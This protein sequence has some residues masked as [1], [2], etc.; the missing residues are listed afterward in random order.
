MSISRRVARPLLAS[1]FV[2]GGLDALRN[3]EGKVKVA[4]PV[5]GPIAAHV[6]FLPEDTATLVRLNGGVMVGAAVLLAL[7]KLRRLAALVLIGSIMPTT[8]AGHRFWEETDDATRAQQ[9]FHFLKNLGLLGGL[10][11]ALVDTEGE[12]SLSWRTK[13]RAARASRALSSGRGRAVQ[14]ANRALAETGDLLGM[15]AAST[16]DAAS[17][18]HHPIRP[19]GSAGQSVTKGRKRTRRAQRKAHQARLTKAQTVAVEAAKRGRAVV[20]PVV[21]S[22]LGRAGEVWGTVAEHLPVG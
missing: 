8:Y 13:R 21:A 19:M 4:E 9:L 22:G 1:T 6:P 16:K 15:V 5:A 18:A 12:P 20:D 10:I 11:L 17:H 7:G 2:V 14:Q 3:P